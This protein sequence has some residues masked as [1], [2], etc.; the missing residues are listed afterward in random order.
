MGVMVATAFVAAQTTVPGGDVSGTW[1]AVG[2]PYLIEGEITVQSS[3]SLVIEPG[4]DVIFQGHYKLIVN[5]W[6]LAE[7]TETDS[8]LFAASDTSEGWHG[9]RLMDATGES[10]LMYC[11]IKNGYATG[12]EPDNN[13]G[14]IYCVNSPLN[15]GYSMIAENRALSQFG[16][17]IYMENCSNN[18]FFNNV[19][20]YNVADHGAGIIWWCEDGLIENNDISYNHAVS[21]RASGLSIIGSPII[22]NNII[23]WNTMNFVGGGCIDMAYS[24]NPLM[25]GNQVCNNNQGAITALVGSS[26][27]LV[28]NTICNN[29]AF[30]LEVWNNSHQFGRNN[31]IY[32]NGDPFIVNIGCSVTLE[33]SL[34]EGGWPGNGNIDA[35]P[36]FVPGPAGDY[37]LS[38]IAA[39]QSQQSP[40]VDAGDPA[41]PF[42]SGTTRTD[43]VPDEGIVDM[44]YH[45]PPY[46][47]PPPPPPQTIILTPYN[48]P[49]I[50]PASG[51]SFDYNIEAENTVPWLV[52][53]DV[54][55]DVLKPNG[56]YTVAVMGPVNL[57]LPGNASIDR[58]RI[59][60]VP[61]FAPPG[62]YQYCAY[63]GIYPDSVIDTDSFPLEKLE[64]GGDKIRIGDWFN[65]GES[66]GEW[67]SLPAVEPPTEFA[68]FNAYPNPFNPV[69][70]IRFA[71][72]EATRVNLSVYDISGR[73]V[74]T[75]VEGWRDAGI[76]EVAFD[77]SKL[78]S[79]VYLY[80]LEAGG[81][82]ASGKMVLMK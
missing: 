34:V 5:G 58:D 22:R 57:D 1:E 39:G 27:E 41:S 75:L 74:T 10:I 8:I 21:Q 29:G 32:G 65:S 60:D 36:L 6:L 47:P 73:L 81:F 45:Y 11:I 38:Q 3:D 14:G 56:F 67:I 20:Q 55:C 24:S 9:I 37:Y 77:G 18:H 17:G 16:G 68:L 71:L 59:Q 54:W 19:V 64:T 42:T 33:Y 46:L 31:I 72:P 78:T 82:T 13:G 48:L 76:H 62:I 69:T 35:D 26:P 66:F 40:C 30:A 50:I 51:G 79:G 4:V 80:R 61:D 49:I 12:L 25:S 23:N 52:N 28:N 44:G 70:T 2:S 53:C 63:I 15:V 7:G 43:E